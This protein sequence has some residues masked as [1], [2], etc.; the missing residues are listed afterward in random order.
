MRVYHYAFALQTVPAFVSCLVLLRVHEPKAS[1]L[2]AVFGAM[3]N[4]RTLGAMLGLTF[5]ANYVFVKP[6]RK[7]PR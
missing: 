4:V 6:T 1:P 7:G 3:R 2:S 5:V